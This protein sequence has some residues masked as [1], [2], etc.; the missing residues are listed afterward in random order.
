MS[1]TM[2]ILL[3]ACLFTA[4]ESRSP[5]LGPTPT[6]ADL[7][8]TAA[9]QAQARCVNVVAEGSASL[10]IVA[11]PNG[12]V[13]FGAVWT[14]VT[15]GEWSGQMASVVIDQDQSGQHGATHLTL[16]HAFQLPDGDYFLTEDRA[17]C[18][19]A[20]I[21]L[22]TC[23]VN[24]T[25]TITSGTGVFTNANGSLHNHGDINFAHNTLD[26]VIRGRVCGD[27]L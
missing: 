5:L 1:S 23:R 11:L 10:G 18:A 20:G 16:E 3:L 27:G 2:R 25:L 15:L 24:D 7:V 13:G 6:A 17:V 9:S 4:C 21:D 14:P 19:P 12:T 8:T 26:F 22:A